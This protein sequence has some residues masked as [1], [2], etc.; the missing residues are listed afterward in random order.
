MKFSEFEAEQWEQLKPFLDTVLLPV[1]GLEGT[2]NPVQVVDTLEQLRDV[3]D[4]IEGPFTGRIVT[5]PAVQ[6]GTREAEQMK[7][8]L[9]E[10]VGNLKQAGFTYVICVTAR[11][12]DKQW[13]PSNADLWIE[14]NDG[15]TQEAVSKAIQALWFPP[16]EP[17]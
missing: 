5:Y 6:Y 4:W 14:A 10:W 2:E 11:Q 15:W 16:A 13:Q 17:N 12:T 9:Q 3:M 7:D 1:T 8:I